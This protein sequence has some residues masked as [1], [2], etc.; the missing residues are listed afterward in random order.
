MNELYRIK[1]RNMFVVTLFSE[2]LY[3]GLNLL[4]VLS[5]NVVNVTKKW[6]KKVTG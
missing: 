2:T 3:F 5:F 6:H 4:L 1:I